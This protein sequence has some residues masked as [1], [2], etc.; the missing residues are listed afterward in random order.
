MKKRFS[1][2]MTLTA[3]CMT[4]P[5]LFLSSCENLFNGAELK[6]KIEN[7]VAYANSPSYTISVEQPKN[8]GIIK[9]PAGGTVSKKVGDIFSI[10]F[11]PLIDWEFVRWKIIDSATKTEIPNGEYLELTSIDESE[12]ECTLVNAPPES[13]K[14]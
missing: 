14:L 2:F 6:S 3:C 5:I 8:R 1:R 11:E 7:S 4:F 10:N 9:S 12:T 13:I